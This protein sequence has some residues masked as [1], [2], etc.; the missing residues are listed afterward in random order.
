MKSTEKSTVS[1]RTNKGLEYNFK[2]LYPNYKRLSSSQMLLYEKDPEAFFLEYTMGVRR[3]ST[4]AMNFGKLFSAAYAD[5]KYDWREGAKYLEIKPVRLYDLLE[6]ALKAMPELPKEQCEFQLR[7]KYNGWYM[8]I[9]PDA[10]IQTQHDLI[11]NKTGQVEWTQE[12]ANFD[13]QITL[14]AWG[15]WKKYGIQP[16]RIWLNWVD[17]SPKATKLI[18]TFK[19][20]RSIKNLR[21][22]DARVEVVIK[23]IE[24]ENFTKNIYG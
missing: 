14:Q 17:T 5:R 20:T 8:R 16:R 11:E 22:M 7:F 3:E 10:V 21:N 12:R 1:R 15:Y 23:G 18:H 6:R 24:A 4:N 2:E 13:D 19:T 9:T